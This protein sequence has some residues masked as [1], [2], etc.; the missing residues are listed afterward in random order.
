MR[1]ARVGF[2]LFIVFTL[3][4]VAARPAWAQAAPAAAAP[5]LTR[6]QMRDF[7]LHARVIRSKE[8]GTGVTHPSR[9]TLT[10]GTI[11]HDAAFQAIDEKKAVANLTGSGGGPAVEFN[12]VDAWRYNLAAQ[13]LA[14][15]V[16]L[17]SM[18]PVHVERTYNRKTGS[19]SWWVSVMMDEGQRLKA[20]TKPP[21]NND[22]NNQM[23]RMRVFA[24]LLRDTDRNLGNVLIT[25]QWKIMMIDF[26][27][28]FRLQS[29]LP[30]PK[31]LTKC[32]RVLLG[33][34]EALTAPSIKTA[35]GEYLTKSEIEAVL[36]R[37]DLLVTHYRDLI[38]ANGEGEVLYD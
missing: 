24:A 25:P 4:G 23:Y 22:W 28:A 19:L 3:V 14:G 13:A 30:N 26:T 35:V 31:D 37:R 32:D 6:D 27:R 18:M 20:G 34:I 1:Y 8:I 29:Q 11:T 33:K 36:K 10:D 2:S 9:L 5:E 12:F 38:K 16:G 17:E 21:D 7:L 15:M